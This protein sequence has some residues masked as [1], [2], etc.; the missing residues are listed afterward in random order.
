MFE[1]IRNYF[2][3]RG[4]KG[5]ELSEIGKIVIAIFLLVVLVGGAYL[6]FRGGGGEV[7]ASV[8]DFLRFGRTA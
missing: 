3:I 1:V 2:R 7:L 5:M 4:K 8:R 6:L